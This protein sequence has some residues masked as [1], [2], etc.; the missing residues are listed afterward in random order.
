MVVVSVKM[1]VQRTEQ[2]LGDTGKQRAE[3]DCWDR[4]LD[5]AATCTNIPSLAIFLNVP[6]GRA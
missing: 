1:I 6:A 4:V 2:C 3:G 5:D